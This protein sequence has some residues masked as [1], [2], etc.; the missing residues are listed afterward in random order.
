MSEYALPTLP[1][2]P[3]LF[4]EAQPIDAFKLA[5]AQVVATAWEED[6]AKIVAGVDTGKKGADLALAIPRFKK[7]KPDEWSKKV[8]DAVSNCSMPM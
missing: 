1:S 7:G 6:V 2:V 4:P 8:V 3:G 5:V